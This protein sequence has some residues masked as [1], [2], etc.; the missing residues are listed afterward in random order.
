MLWVVVQLA[1]TL[2][3]SSDPHCSRRGGAGGGGER[4][5]GV[6][7]WFY[8]CGCGWVRVRVRVRGASRFGEYCVVG[9]GVAA[10]LWLC[11]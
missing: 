2:M 7:C 4:E 8:T 3:T 9:V 6:G 5:W 1:G 10:S 11:V